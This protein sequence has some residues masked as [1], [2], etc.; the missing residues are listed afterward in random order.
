MSRTYLSLYQCLVQVNLWHNKY[1]VYAVHAGMVVSCIPDL[2]CGPTL[3]F[4]RPL[5]LFLR[6]SKIS[7]V[8][9]M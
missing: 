9:N 8:I 2:R 3:A 7:A 4:L 1:L 5:D 6:Y